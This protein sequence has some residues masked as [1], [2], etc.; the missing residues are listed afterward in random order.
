MH[1]TSNQPITEPHMLVMICLPFWVIFTC[2]WG[3][4]PKSHF[5]VS[6]NYRHFVLN[7]NTKT[8]WFRAG[9]AAQLSG[10]AL[11]LIRSTCK[12]PSVCLLCA[13][14]GDKLLQLR[15]TLNGADRAC[16]TSVNTEVTVNN[17]WTPSSCPV[18]PS[19]PECGIMH[20]SHESQ[21]LNF[22]QHEVAHSFQFSPI[23]V[24]NPE[25]TRSSLSSTSCSQP[26]SFRLT[27]LFAY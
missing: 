3:L 15:N 17:A 1:F 12:Q 11:T 10:N 14:A 9:E 19:C 4:K 6:L 26:F 7:F 2:T 21:Q 20:R 16:L 24:A 8:F 22:E 23:K 18:F 13:A 25:F 5:C 27:C